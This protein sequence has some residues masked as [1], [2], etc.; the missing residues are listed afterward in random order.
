MNNKTNP[1]IVPGRMPSPP[2]FLIQTNNSP[3]EATA[4]SYSMEEFVP[5]ERT[6][7]IDH[8]LYQ[9]ALEDRKQA[10]ISYA[11]IYGRYL[12]VLALNEKLVRKYKIKE[13]YKQRI[14]KVYENAL[15]TTVHHGVSKERAERNQEALE[16]AYSDVQ[17][18]CEAL[19]VS[20]RVHEEKFKN[21]LSQLG[22]AEA[23]MEQANQQF[24]AMA[25]EF[26]NR[27]ILLEEADRHIQGYRVQTKQMDDSIKEWQYKLSISRD[28][29][30]SLNSKLRD[31]QL[32]EAGISTL[33]G[34][35]ATSLTKAQKQIYE[36]EDKLN[37]ITDESK[38]YIANLEGEVER[39]REQKR[40][41]ALLMRSKKIAE[42]EG[43][44]PAP[45]PLENSEA[46]KAQWND[47]YSK[48]SHIIDELTSHSGKLNTDTQGPLQVQKMNPPELISEAG[49]LEII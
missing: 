48:W 8:V 35:L 20:N 11:E 28:E 37:R 18:E 41:E 49:D 25:E 42:G 16:Q 4:H 19:R 23:Q 21:L 38:I 40:V 34:E 39:F 47:L 6:K 29:N 24:G 13:R 33:N 3:T 9:N 14:R 30:L 17:E 22:H 27:R 43:E 45:M 12:E 44:L 7:N 31:S 10:E 26:D 5:S 36:L 2:D 46:P 1:N 15:N 32:K